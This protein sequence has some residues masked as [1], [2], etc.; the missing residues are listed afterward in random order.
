MGKAPKMSWNFDYEHILKLQSI[1]CNTAAIL[2]MCD[3]RKKY[4]VFLVNTPSRFSTLKKKV[5]DN[6][7]PKFIGYAFENSFDDRKFEDVKNDHYEVYTFDDKILYATPS[8]EYISKRQAGGAVAKKNN[9]PW[10]WEGDIHARRE[11]I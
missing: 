9:A 8:E 2:I 1:D 10:H 3:S 4:Q 6:K 11:N 7:E 5:Y